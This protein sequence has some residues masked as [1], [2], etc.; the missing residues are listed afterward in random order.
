[1]DTEEILSTIKEGIFNGRIPEG[2]ATNDPEMALKH[3][4]LMKDHQMTRAAIILFGKKPEAIFPQCILRLARFKGNDKA[5]FLDNRQVHGNIFHLLRA[6]M[7]FANFHLPIASTF[8]KDSMMR[9]D[10]PLFQIP[11]LREAITNALT[12]RDYSFTGGSVSFAIYDNRL[13]FWSYGLLPPGLAIE[14]LVDRVL[15][16]SLYDNLISTP[17]L[18]FE[19]SQACRKD[20]INL[21][22]DGADKVLL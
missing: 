6:A 20:T 11:V 1:L 17:C 5:E 3:L 22:K 16:A 9:E 21:G 10:K 12:H 19:N 4:G 15:S 13:E 8:P 14:E 18:A 2:Y 7:S